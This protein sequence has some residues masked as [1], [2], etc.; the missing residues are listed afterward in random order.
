[1][2][3]VKMST[4]SIC[5]EAARN[6]SQKY[7]KKLIAFTFNHQPSTSSS[8][9]SINSSIICTIMTWFDHQH[10][11]Y[12]VQ[13]WTPSTIGSITSDIKLTTTDAEMIYAA[14]CLHF[15]HTE[16]DTYNW[17]LFVFG[18]ELAILSIPRPAWVK[19][20]LNSS[21]KGWPHIDWPPLPVPSGSPPWIWGTMNTN[22]W[23][24]IHACDSYTHRLT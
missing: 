19:F 3:I 11:Y 10:P 4:R 14:H 1:M 20:G 8:N 23:V 17:D 5:Y 18:P 12:T 16:Q 7:H 24:I 22:D 6:K 13:C 2:L 21:L 15:T 9:S